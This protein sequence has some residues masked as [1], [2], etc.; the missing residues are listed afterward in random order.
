MAWQGLSI[1]QRRAHAPN[2]VSHWKFLKFFET[3]LWICLQEALARRPHLWFI[4][5]SKPQSLS[6]L[7]QMVNRETAAFRM[8]V[9]AA[10][11]CCRL[12]WGIPKQ[13]LETDFADVL[14]WSGG[15]SST[16]GWNPALDSVSCFVTFLSMR[17]WLQLFFLFA[18]AINGFYV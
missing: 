8:C 3:C 17:T 16:T 2:Q 18:M 1:L 10:A 7:P 11:V 12:G 14:C 13:S 4:N 15:S 6:E 9:S 5:F